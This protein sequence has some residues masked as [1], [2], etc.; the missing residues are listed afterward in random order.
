MRKMADAA[1]GAVAETDRVH[2]R[3][4]ARLALGEKALG[5]GG[6]QRIRHR[7]S[8]AGT[9]DQKRVAAGDDLGGLLR[10]DHAGHHGRSYAAP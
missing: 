8:G 9:A 2:R 3:Q 5:D 7:M 10:C 1:F 6:D 4:I